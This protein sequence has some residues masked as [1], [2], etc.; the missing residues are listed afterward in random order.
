MPDS[1]KS[2]Y[3][4]RNI[5][6]ALLAVAAVFFGGAFWETMKVYHAE[7]NPATDSR[8]RL[9]DLALDAAGI[10]AEE[11]KTAWMLLVEIFEAAEEIRGEINAQYD[12]GAFEPRD[13]YDGEL[14][15]DRVRDGR[16]LPAD[17]APERR[18]FA[19]LEQR[20]VRERFHRFA[21]GPPGLRPIKGNGVLGFSGMVDDLSRARNL[22]RIS[23][24]AM[25]LA[26]GEG[27]LA[28]AVNAFDQTLALARTM[29]LQPY[30]ISYLTAAAIEALAMSELRYELMELEFDEPSCRSLLASLDRHSGFPTVG[31]ALEAER[32]YFEDWVQ[33]TY[34]DDGAGDGFLVA[35]PVLESGFC[36]PSEQ[37]L[38]GAVASRFFTASRAEIQDAHGTLMDKLVRQTR[39][40]AAEQA[41]AAA[42]SDAFVEGLSNRY[43][44]VRLLSSAL[45]K[46]VQNS[47]V[48]AV[49]L[50]GMRVMVA[51]ELYRA[52]HGAYPDSLD[53][54]AGDIVT[55]P[56]ADP[57]HG[58]PFGYRLLDGDP[59]GRA[60]LLYSIGL[61]RVDD[62]G[63][64]LSPA[65]REA[66]GHAA[67]LT[68][69]AVSNADH[70]INEPR[71]VWGE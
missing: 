60:Y 70:V 4:P 54:L 48:R 35:A 24:S 56:P 32:I 52:R 15:Y 47:T 18:A 44:M 53:Q 66:H 14:D 23:V 61:D 57:L 13:E 63:A 21:D 12:A 11:G 5:L 25:R 19:L 29:A 17:L 3:R 39:L 27:D 7:P 58:L 65:D 64:E 28:G 22:A 34:S 59:D 36:A 69:P 37:S 20:G 10:T 51:L 46:F 49:R 2:W 31:Y 62:G 6:T 42:E 50:E 16:A 38:L 33:W 41:G 40:P 43:E 1:K 67:P 26:A 8:R 45:G 30:L 68:T 71:P 55:Q 9:H